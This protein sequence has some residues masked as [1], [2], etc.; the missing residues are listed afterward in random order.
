MTKKMNVLFV[1]MQGRKPE[2][3]VATQTTNEVFESHLKIMNLCYLY[4]H[5]IPL[6]TKKEGEYK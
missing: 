4:L 1:R 3:Q 2:L 6:D 5:P